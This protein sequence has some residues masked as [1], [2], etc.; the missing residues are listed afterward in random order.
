MN[1]RKV[2]RLEIYMYDFGETSGSIQNGHRPVVVIQDDRFNENSPTTVVAAIT[3]AVK[4]EHLPSHIYIGKQFGLSRPSMVLLEQIQTINQ[5]DLG[6]YIGIIDNQRLTKN[7]AIGIKKTL[8]MWDYT[9]RDKTSIR[10]LC[11][12]CMREYMN[13]GSYI[14]RRLDPFQNDRD[15]CYRCSRP[16]WDYVITERMQK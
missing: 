14:V 3:T 12:N 4:K 9:P 10:C 15:K 1:S 7:L 16:G 6:D 2:K 5:Y 13:T 8:G 11:P